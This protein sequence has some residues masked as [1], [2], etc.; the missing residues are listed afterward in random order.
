[1][2]PCLKDCTLEVMELIVFQLD[3]DDIRNLR[4][5]CRSLAVKCTGKRFRS[6]FRS[7]QVEITVPMLREFAELTQ[8]GGL[9][10]Q[11]QE[12]TLVGIADSATAKHLWAQKQLREVETVAGICR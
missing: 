6:F 3:L 2:A 8:A 9:A 10:C 5:T 4:Q 1:M 7:K 11:I 12:L